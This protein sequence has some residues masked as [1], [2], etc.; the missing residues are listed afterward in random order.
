MSLNT[1]V[2]VTCFNGERFLGEQLRSIVAQNDPPDQIVLGDDASTD[3]SVAVAREAL[4][5]YRGSL[6][7]LDSPRQVG[8]RENLRRCFERAS[9]E[10][11]IWADQDDVWR[12]D[13]VTVLCS[14]LEAAPSATMAF[15]DAR[16]I[17]EAGRPIGRT[18]WSA[19]GLSDKQCR[20]WADDAIGVLMERT[21]VTGP[22]MAVRRSLIAAALPLPAACWPDEWLALIAVLREET[23][24]LVAEQ[25]IDYRVHGANMAGLPGRGARD[26]LCQAGWPR[27][28]TLSG[29]QEAC[30][31]VGPD[32]KAVRRL[33]EAVIFHR[34]RPTDA[35]RPLERAA[36]VLSLSARGQYARYGRG[37]PAALHDLAAPALYGRPPRSIKSGSSGAAGT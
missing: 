33:Q 25:L 5:P 31:R 13:K 22:T 21:V 19:V 16:V 7:V 29:W 12:P 9:G 30:D 10:L 17:D 3:G 27:S 32:G 2:V 15:S 11:I 35:A 4:G 24:V 8:H 14:A 26:R 37:W 6:V 36:R 34:Q 23:P 1:S 28:D 20:R 18:L